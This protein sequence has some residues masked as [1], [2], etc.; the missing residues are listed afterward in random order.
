[1]TSN[2]TCPRCGEPFDPS[3]NPGGLCPA[4]LLARGLESEPGNDSGGPE[5]P[6]GGAPAPSPEELAPHFPNLVIED[7]I[8]RGGMGSVYR[9]RQ[10]ELDRTVALKIVPIRPEHGPAFTERF[11]R[12]ARALAT[13][14]HP[15]IVQVYDSGQAGEWIYFVME[16]VDGVNLRQI[17]SQ[18]RADPDRALSIVN[19]VCDSLRYAHDQG[20]VHRDIKP[21]N[22]L[23]NQ[24]GT[25]KLVD[26]GLARLLGTAQPEVTLTLTGQAMGTPHYMA[27]E[28]WKSPQDVDH[29]ADIYSLGVVFYELLTGELPIGRFEPPSHAV[30]VDVRLDEVVLKTLKTKPEHRY[31]H[32]SEVKSDLEQVGNSPAPTTTHSQTGIPASQAKDLSGFEALPLVVGWCLGFSGLIQAIAWTTHRIQYGAPGGDALAEYL[33]TGIG[34]GGVCLLISWF[35]HSWVLKREN[36]LGISGPR[37][38]LQRP[39]LLPCL[40][41][42][43]FVGFIYAS[44]ARQDTPMTESTW[45][46]ASLLL[47]L[48]V[49][50]GITRL[51]AGLVSRE[52][53]ERS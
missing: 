5:G 52:R 12:E 40:F 36:R 50:G 51:L 11:R 1:M 7:P 23:I 14:N 10:V 39:G 15:G 44:N 48:C 37:V 30:Q 45:M 16:H 8:G 6:A 43:T 29:R 27:P 22:I 41:L 9:A 34:I 21:E 42:I 24:A 4:C 25:V 18:E 28:Q 17:L 33:F 13:L 26:F 19:Q 31:Q 3:Q 53:G 20:V 38:W 2:T 47:F 32:T 49:V 35:C 46:S